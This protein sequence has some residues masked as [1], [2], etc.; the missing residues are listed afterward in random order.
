M[1]SVTDAQTPTA[2]VTTYAYDNLYQLLSAK[3]GTTTKESYTYDPVG[4]RLSSLGVSPYVNNTSNELTSTPNASY[5]YDY[6]GNTT[7]KTDSTGTTNYNW[8]YEKRLA[9]VT[10]PGT[11]GTVS[12]KY[13]PL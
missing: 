12:F 1:T 11:G 9:S 4:N 5:S 2:G 7:S 13:E 3:Q 8:D 6:N 10:L